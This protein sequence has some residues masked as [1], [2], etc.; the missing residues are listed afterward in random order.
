MIRNTQTHAADDRVC[1]YARVA[2]VSTLGKAA[3]NSP[4][5]A[6]AARSRSHVATAGSD[7]GAAVRLSPT[8]RRQTSSLTTNENGSAASGSSSAV[9]SASSQ[10]RFAA[11]PGELVGLLEEAH[12]VACGDAPRVVEALVEVDG[13]KLGQGR[14]VA[15]PRIVG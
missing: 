15:N 5:A 4:R 11:D 2:A 12:E 9:R 10:P 13:S 8:I 1:G 14:W 7:E 6:A 3:T